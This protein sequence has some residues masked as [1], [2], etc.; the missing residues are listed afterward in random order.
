M[1]EG[2]IAWSGDTFKR[3]PDSA[4]S[5]AMWVKVKK[6]GI[7]NWFANGKKGDK[8]FY[9][10]TKGTAVPA[11]VWTHVAGTFDSQTGKIR[12]SNLLVN[13]YE[14]KYLFLRVQY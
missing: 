3:K 12:K 2:S 1:N 4:I 6:S 10:K 11:K 7:I 9:T 5:I 8:T 13:A 14:A